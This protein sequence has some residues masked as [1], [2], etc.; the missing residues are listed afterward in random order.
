MV[1]NW[2]NSDYGWQ[3]KKKYH[4]CVGLILLDAIYDRK[5][6]DVL[7]SNCSLYIHGHSAGGTNPSL[8]EAMY[9]E[10]PIFAFASGYNE[11][12]TE[13]KAV[14]FDSRESLIALIRGRK[15]YDLATLGKNLKLI[16]DKSYRWKTIAEKYKKLI[17]S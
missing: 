2:N 14:Y 13:N 4:N 3:T 10:L 11:Y 8:V 15:G 1:G 5:K 6:L 16:A 17:L 9:L 12:T 7:R